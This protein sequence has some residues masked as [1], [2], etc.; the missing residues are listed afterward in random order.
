VLI[1]PNGTDAGTIAA[2]TRSALGPPPKLVFR[3][4]GAGWRVTAGIQVVIVAVILNA[5]LSDY[6]DSN[7]R[8][9]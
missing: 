3:L 2:S 4:E 6:A 7:A 9:A 8:F 1:L 5:I